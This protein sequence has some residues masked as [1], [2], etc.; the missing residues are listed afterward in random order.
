MAG[1]YDAL[2]V[3]DP[4]G[5]LIELNPR[6]MEY[7]LYRSEDVWDKP[8]SVLIPGVTANMVG[9]I[10]KGLDESR[11]IM[12]DAR[13]QRQ[14]GTTFAAEV[15]ISVIDLMN[16]GDLVFTVR[17]TERRR[18]QWEMMRSKANAFEISQSACFVCDSN[19]QFRAVNQAFLDMFDF[20]GEEAVLG[21]TFEELMPDEP[22]P[23]FFDRALAGE[24]LSYKVAADT[25]SGNVKEVEVQMAPDFQAKDKVVGVV[26]SIFEC[27]RA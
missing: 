18:K 3:T 22:L 2:L 27:D 24:S 1:L 17:N 7:F 13:C 21:R 8:V 26:G 19:R 4:N 6:A 15:T 20:S 5:H 11:H 23:S 14:D 25:E 16:N 10:R 12:L 9:R